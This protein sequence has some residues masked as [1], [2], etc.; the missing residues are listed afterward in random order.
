MTIF[1]NSF[2]YVMPKACI[3]C[4]KQAT[5]LWKLG[6]EKVWKPHFCFGLFFIFT[7]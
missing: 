4:D 2:E 1:Q 3:S 7:P 5:S 6:Y